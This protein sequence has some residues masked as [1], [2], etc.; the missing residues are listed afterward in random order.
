MI[1]NKSIEEVARE[2]I[3]GKWGNGDE[4]KK[5]LTNAGYNYAVVQDRVN[6]LMK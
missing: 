1:S 3:A 2:V 4:R 6:Q 5:K